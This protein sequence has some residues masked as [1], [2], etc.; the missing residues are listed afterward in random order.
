MSAFLKVCLEE[1]QPSEVPC[2]GLHGQMSFGSAK[3]WPHL[4]KVHRHIKG[5]DKSCSLKKKVLSFA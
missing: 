5:S 2:K 4:L 3:Y 1:Y